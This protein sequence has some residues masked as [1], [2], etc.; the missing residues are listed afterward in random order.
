MLALH[1][2]CLSRRY[3]LNRLNFLEGLLGFGLACFALSG[4]IARSDSRVLESSSKAS[5]FIYESLELSLHLAYS[6]LL[7]FSLDALLGRF[8]F[9]LRHRLLQGRHFDRGPW[10]IH[11]DPIILQPNLF[12]IYI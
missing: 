5:C 12:Y 4:A 7:L 6:G 1:N 3:L 8:V 2:E 9:S 10:H 11:D